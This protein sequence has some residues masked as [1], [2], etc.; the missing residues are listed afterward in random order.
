METSIQR[1]GEVAIE[2]AKDVSE[3]EK[4]DA[5]VQFNSTY[6]C[7]EWYRYPKSATEEQRAPLLT[8]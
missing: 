2:I 7:V 8:D 1:E 3:V 5:D 6:G 4:A